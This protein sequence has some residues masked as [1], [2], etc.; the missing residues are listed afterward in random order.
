MLAVCRTGGFADYEFRRHDDFSRVGRLAIGDALQ[1]NL[2]SALS[3]LEQRL[4]HRGERG[5]GVS[6]RLNIVKSNNRDIFRNAKA[7][8][9]KSADSAD[10]GDVVEAE[11]AVKSRDFSSRPCIGL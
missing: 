5:R 4:T 9:F 10:R 7:G 8:V 6:G 11:D 3:H 2:R 1:Q